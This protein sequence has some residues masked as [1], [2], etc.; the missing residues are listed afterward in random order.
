MLREFVHRLPTAI[1]RS[2]RRA[3][4][5]RSRRSLARARFRLEDL[6]GRALLSH[7]SIHALAHHAAAQQDLT[8]PTVQ[9]ATLSAPVTNPVAT[10]GSL[11]VANARSHAVD[12][13]FGSATK[14]GTH[15]GLDITA[16]VGTAV[17]ASLS[18][19]VVSSGFKNNGEGYRV[20]VLDHDGTITMYSHL[21]PG[22][23]DGTKKGGAAPNG[24]VVQA[25]E[26]IGA[27]GRSGSTPPKGPAFL[28]FQMFS[29]S[30]TP[31]VPD[32]NPANPGSLLAPDWAFATPAPTTTVT[33]TTTGPVQLGPLQPTSSDPPTTAAVTQTTVYLSLFPAA[34]QQ[35]GYSNQQVFSILTGSGLTATQA[36]DVIG[37]QE[38][39][40][41]NTTDNVVAQNF[42][43]SYK[44]P[45]IAQ[46]RYVVSS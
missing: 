2:L 18:G 25:G 11:D 6:E 15:Y 35:Y 29:A 38:I 3:K 23:L 5:A 9:L 31:I 39:V 37:G 21:A 24:T 17:T 20:M 26:I 42:V 16:P 46:V 41:L 32:I 10:N 30:G 27:V 34:I 13:R 43:S 45:N 12:G 1:H 22:G 14:L 33:P 28:H 4:P 19:V 8:P 7:A 40:I 44:I 36:N